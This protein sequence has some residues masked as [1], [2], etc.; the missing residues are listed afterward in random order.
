MPRYDFGDFSQVVNRMVHPERQPEAI[1]AKKQEYEQGQD[2]IKNFALYGGYD[3]E[4]VMQGSREAM[5]GPL[6]ADAEVSRFQELQAGGKDSPAPAKM[7]PASK[8]YK[9]FRDMFSEKLAG[10]GLNF[11]QKKELERLHADETRRTK[12]TPSGGT[13]DKYAGMGGAAKPAE[14]EEA[15]TSWW[16]SLMGRGK[17]DKKKKDSLGIY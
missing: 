14:L 3:P 13:K 8:A 11:E 7:T 15:T 12:A 16:D 4:Q 2:A 10:S 9:G 17:K 1:A 5:A 6:A